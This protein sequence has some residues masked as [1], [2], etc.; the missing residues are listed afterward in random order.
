MRFITSGREYRSIYDDNTKFIGKFFIFLKKKKPENLLSIGIV[1]SKKVGNA[2]VRNKIK[3]RVK[4]FFRENIFDVGYDVV[5]IAGP[6]SAA[7]DWLS[8]KKE[9]N[10]YFMN[11]KKI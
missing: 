11:L 4:A 10:D 3:R 8:I 7:A 2:V 6:D 1:V 5:I 9:L